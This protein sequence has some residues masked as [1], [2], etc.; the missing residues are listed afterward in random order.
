MLNYHVIKELCYISIESRH[1]LEEYLNFLNIPEQDK[2]NIIDQSIDDKH[3]LH[4]EIIMNYFG[5]SN[6]EDFCDYVCYS[7][8]K[9]AEDTYDYYE[10]ECSFDEFIYTMLA[11]IDVNDSTINYIIS[12]KNDNDSFV[13]NQMDLNQMDLNQM[14]LNQMDF[15]VD[16]ELDLNKMNISED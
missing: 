14:D 3:C 10:N 6:V 4:P 16:N 2:D 9:I 1:I 12:F 15:T 5:P 8:I 11:E 13:I 7:I